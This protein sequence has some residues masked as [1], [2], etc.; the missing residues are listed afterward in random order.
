VRRLQITHD[1]VPG[2]A[3]RRN[4]PSQRTVAI[5]GSTDIRDIARATILAAFHD[6]PVRTAAHLLAKS[7]TTKHL[8]HQPSGLRLT[9]HGRQ[10]GITTPEAARVRWAVQRNA[11][12]VSRNDV[13]V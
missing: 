2:P 1:L 9:T 8:A 13:M 4:A 5:A 11:S 6:E 12:V 3:Q 10:P 7:G